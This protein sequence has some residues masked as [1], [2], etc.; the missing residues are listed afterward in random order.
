[1]CS[2]GFHSHI[3]TSTMGLNYLKDKCVVCQPRLLV[4]LLHTF[5]FNK[6]SSYN[7][8]IYP[9]LITQ[10]AIQLSPSHL[11]RN[12]GTSI[13]IRFPLF[14][15]ISNQFLLAVL[16]VHC[17]QKVNSTILDRDTKCPVVSCRFCSSNSDKPCHN[18]SYCKRFLRRQFQFI[19]YQSSYFLFCKFD[20]K[21]LY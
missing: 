7:D 9:R 6:S 12:V 2:C 15:F 8:K 3:S 19:I 11:L 20:K 16:L 13:T 21:R 18:N 1:M 17:T 10:P 14:L 5:L 4:I